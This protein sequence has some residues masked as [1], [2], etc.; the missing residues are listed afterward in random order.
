M[1]RSPASPAA[2]HAEDLARVPLFADLDPEQHQRLLENHRLLSL[3]A[4]ERLVL[5]Q[6]ESQSLFLLRSGLAKVRCFDLDGQE[7]VLALL[8]P[9][10]I[11]GEMALLN[12]RGLRSADVVTL[13]PCSVAILRS[14]PFA[15]LLRSDAR[16][17]LALARL[18]ARRLEVLNHR[19]RLRGG[20][21]ATRLLATLVDLA[22]RSVPG[23]AA[24]DPIPPLPQREL[25]CL[26]G[27]ARETASRA[28]A[29]LRRRGL[30]ADTS[31]GG[32]Q[33]LNLEDL[34]RRGLLP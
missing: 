23:A 22:T 21:A 19:L 7:T 9:G 20:D 32:L 4:E 25:A 2:L 11:C 29:T 18:Q 30:V 17:T 24:T 5:E 16:L 3:P 1:S 12:P 15:A 26:C 10:E 14:G 28:L 6:D 31:D 34:R 33:L 27:L 13:T 8:G